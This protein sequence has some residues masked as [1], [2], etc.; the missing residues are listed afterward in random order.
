MRQKKKREKYFYRYLHA[1]PAPNVVKAM[2]KEKLLGEEVV[3]GRC[4]RRCQDKVKMTLKKAL[5]K[6]KM[7]QSSPNSLYEEE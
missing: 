4:K 5:D 1:S 2:A 3:D 7:D 6:S